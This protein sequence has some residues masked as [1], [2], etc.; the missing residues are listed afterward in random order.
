M[1][2][3]RRRPSLDVVLAY[4][5][6]EVV[7]RFCDEWDVSRSEARRV[8]ADMLRFLWLVDRVHHKLAPV[9][10][11]DEMWHAFLMFT[12]PYAEFSQRMFN[13]MLHHDPTTST[14]KRSDARLRRTAPARA[15]QLDAERLGRDL[16]AV[17]EQLGPRVALRWYVDYQ[18]RY[19]PAFFAT[20][21]RA[22]DTTAFAF[23]E[24][25]LAR[26]RHG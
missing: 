20:K 4:R 2:A 18:D 22:P 8:F 10:I 9:P 12:R 11:I 25:L 6:P 17:Y 23:P 3:T 15:R 5:N 21:R 7:A 14:E 13:R 16:A 19:S 24:E 1:P 26:A